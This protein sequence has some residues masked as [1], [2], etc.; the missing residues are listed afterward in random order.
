M[1]HQDIFVSA[2]ML[3]AK[4]A[5]HAIAR[6]HRYLNYG[7]LGLATISSARGRS[8]IVI[9]GCFEPPAE[10]AD[11]V[12]KK[13]IC[14]ASQT[15]A[16]SIPSSFSI[17]WARQFINE[18]RR[19]YPAIDIVAGGRWVIGQDYNWIQKQLPG[20]DLIVSGTAE[21]RIVDVLDRKTRLGVEGTSA[22]PAALI[23]NES[24]IPS[25]DYRLLEDPD[26]F[27]PSIEVSRGCGMGCSF[28]VERDVSLTDMRSP[29]EIVKEYLRILHQL[30]RE[31]ANPY[32]E[33]SIFKPSTDWAVTLQDCTRS[34]GVDFL[35]RT[36]SRVDSFS[37]AVLASLAASGLKVIDLGL[38]SASPMQLLRM[39]KTSNPDAYLRRASKL[40]RLCK[41][42]GIWAKVNVLF[43][44]GETS[45]TIG[46]T[47]DWL[48]DH[49]GCI[50]GLSVNPLVIYR[51]PES[52]TLIHEI[53]L[54][55]AALKS[56]TQ[57]EEF[58]YA[59]PELSIEIDSVRALELSTA[60]ASEFM[61]ARDYFD[62]KSFSY[63]RSSF[64]YEHF[65]ALASEASSPLPFRMPPDAV[66]IKEGLRATK[67]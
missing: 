59:F 66:E 9:H 14:H 21:S 33:C 12:L 29:E 19:V 60:L 48:R 34:M 17:P 67:C 47:R 6:Q 2:G 44:A 38:E 52:R 65:L 56:P 49:D 23:Q 11:R 13:L 25:L 41:E 55:G 54:H 22:R 42:F 37:E 27:Q 51:S 5:D 61:T 20:L 7:L 39:K 35:W 28:C 58:G 40:L 64:K 62:L 16:L 45:R 1:A 36:E 32:F 46:E 4:K 31:S 3:R 26:G 15:I 63:F 18:I 50:K 8:A 10:T 30:G 57:L 43:Y 24:A 53:G